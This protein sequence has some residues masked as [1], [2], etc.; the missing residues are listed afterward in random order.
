MTRTLSPILL[1]TL[2]LLTTV[3]LKAQATDGKTQQITRAT[4]EI[5]VDGRLDEPAWSD[6][7]SMELAYEVRPGENIE[8]PVRTV[9]M[10]TYD[11]RN[12]YVGFRAFDPDLS[13]IR[14]H[15]SDRDHVGG[16]DWVMVV[17]DTF[18]DERRSFNFLVNPYGVQND[19]VEVN[20]GNSTSWDAIWDS[21]GVIADWGWGVELRIP[22]SS[23][24][25]QRSDRPQ[26]WGFDAVRS[27]PRSVRHHI[28]LFPRDRN[29]NC[30][31][32]Q[33]IKIEGFEG[34]SPGRNIEVVPTLTA[35]RT[36]TRDQ[37]PDGELEEGDIDTE[38]GITARWGITPNLTAAGTINPDFSQVEAD[39]R[40]LDL[41]EPFALFFPEKRPFFQEGS[42]FFDTEFNAVY[43]RTMRDPAWGVKLTGKEG[44]HTI[45]AYVVQD[46]ITNLIFPGSQGSDAETLDIDSTAVVLRY[47]RDIGNRFTFGALFTNREGDNEDYSNRVLGIDGKLRLTDTDTVSFQG[48]VSTTEYPQTI[49]NDFDQP[50]GELDSWAADLF[51]VHD[52]RNFNMWGGYR[53]VG[54]DFRA[55]LGFMPRVDYQRLLGG[56]EYEWVPE[57]DSWYSHLEVGGE[58]VHFEDEDGNLLHR[59]INAMLTY[60]G[61][62][63][64]HA[65]I[66]LMKRREV[67]DGR[68]FDINQVFIHNCMHP[69]S[70]SQMFIN[71][72]I[73]DRIDYANSSL[74]KRLRVQSGF[75]LNLGAH[76][77]LEA[78][79]L[80]ERMEVGGEHLFTANISQA[81]TAYQFNTRT[82]LRAIVHYVDFDYTVATYLDPD[83]LPPNA[84]KELFTQLLFSYKL[85]PQTV[86]FLGYSDS[87][88]GMQASDP[89][90]PSYGLTKEER[91]VFAKIGYA[92]TF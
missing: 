23:L 10:L 47:K 71:I 4:S 89:S 59:D 31:L 57:G 91:T 48:L 11:Q 90:E 58:Y 41:N 36:D 33:A 8:A 28:G 13:K 86:F 18:N 62:L 84:E 22:F 64:T 3:S 51:W 15:L 72:T 38:A 16:D 40:Q 65:R 26:V 75:T 53:R 45:G 78:N 55:D 56:A 24:R 39:A 74:G 42:D 43:T 7:W 87:S 67:Y 52:T 83:S 80:Y 54:K 69:N 70:A 88:F 66:E 14:T 2:I 50:A 25:F 73:G 17:L 77:K 85:N 12:L 82:F 49:V 81:T 34:V 21:D 92:W 46:E 27:Y 32:C 35:A 79:H 9:V 76:L 19:F 63:Q 5:K 6:A 61:P 20:G 60:E 44:P 37:L 1:T 29:S 30:Y 68:E